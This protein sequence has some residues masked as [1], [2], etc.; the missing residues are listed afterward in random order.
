MAGGRVITT[1]D[2][3]STKRV[4]AVDAKDGRTLWDEPTASFWSVDA[5]PTRVY[6]Q[7]WQRVEVRDATT[8]KLLGGV[9]TR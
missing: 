8:G 6:V 9:G 1:Y 7:R 3:S 4:I 2:E 5:S